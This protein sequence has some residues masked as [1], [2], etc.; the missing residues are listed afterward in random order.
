MR[1][2]SELTWMRAMGSML[3]LA[4]G[5]PAL[6]AEDCP[7]TG[8]TRE[9]LQALKAET[10]RIEA[11]APRHRLAQDLLACLSHPDPTLRD[12]IALQA[13]TTW[14]R[15]DWIDVQTRLALLEALQSELSQAEGRDPGFT[16]PFAALVLAEVARTDRRQAWLTPEQRAGLVRSAAR[17]LSSVR[18]YR[19]FVAGEGWRHGVAHGADLAMQLAFNPALDKAQLDQLLE[20]VASQVAP[21]GHAYVFGEPERLARPV[22]L[23][24]AR[25]LHSEA[26]WQAWLEAAAAP[27]AGGWDGVFDDA[28]GLV[29]RHDVRAFLLGLYVQARESPVAGVQAMLPALRAQLEKVP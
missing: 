7:P 27:P 2:L 26:E 8:W 14:L 22:L 23:V 5:L 18:D 19:G 15:N 25:G 16:K 29:R 10:F 13:F 9:S 21:A 12:D 17:Y 11:D 6:A 4:A 28:A 24:A 1:S 3:L 20:A